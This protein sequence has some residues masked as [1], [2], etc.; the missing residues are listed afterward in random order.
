MEAAKEYISCPNCGTTIDVNDLLYHQLEEQIEAKHAQQLRQQR[1]A[2][3]ELEQTVKRREQEL[4]AQQKE[5]SQAIEMAVQ[6]Q[7]AKIREQ[8]RSEAKRAAADEQAQVVQ[9]L[10]KELQEKMERLKVLNKTRAELERVKREKDG[11]REELELESQQK[12]SEAMK[13]ERE[14]IQRSE[15]EKNE[16]KIKEKQQLVDD[17][18]KKLQEA[19]RKA[20]QGSMQS[21]GEVQELAIEEWLVEQFPMDRIEEIKKGAQ[22]ADCLQIVNT[23]AHENCGSIY[24][25]SKRTKAF[26]PSWVEKFKADIREKSA[27]IGVLVT[28]AMPAD[29]DR[30]GLYQGIW[31]CSYEEFK[32]LAAVL[33]QSIIAIYEAGQTQVNKGGKMEMLYDFL[34]GNEFRQQVEAIVEGFTQMKSDLESEKRAMNAQWKK[35]E[36]QLEKVILN[37]TYMYSSVKGIAGSAIGDMPLLELPGGEDE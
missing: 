12:F 13:L 29:L 27:G 15:A 6:E 11:L 22:G 35:R 4:I 10:Q 19:Q 7:V 20:E 31:V 30:M 9:E 28:S 34:T 21:Q 1:S 14:K 24:Y 37:T 23:R 17:L 32:G 33:R 16:L 8:T 18:S 36:K 5:S 2:L 26:Q 25:E 3:S